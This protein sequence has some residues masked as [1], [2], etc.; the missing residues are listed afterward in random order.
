MP[1]SVVRQAVRTIADWPDVGSAAVQIA[2]RLK[3]NDATRASAG[4][5]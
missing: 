3:Q 1:R 4:T 2:N 5:S